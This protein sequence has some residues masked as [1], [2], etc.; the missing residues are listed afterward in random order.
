MPA[1]R[2]PAVPAPRP[3]AA[4][5]PAPDPVPAPRKPGRPRSERA[6]RAILEATLE[7][8]ARCGADGLGIEQVAARAGVGKATI[9]RRWPCKEDLLLEAV[10]R[11]CT[12]LPQPQ[13]RSVRADLNAVIEALCKEAADPR[14]ARQF[15][16]P[17]GDGLKYPRLLAR[18]SQLVME[19]RR[20]LIRSVL[21]R[22]VATGEL[23]EDTDIE[24][25]TLLLT[26]AV[27]AR[28]R[29]QKEV[30]PARYARRVVAEL[31]RG[32]AAR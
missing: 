9:Y 12:P 30:T 22:G 5:A 27:L 2:L 23:R 14:R 6:D 1:A 15:A 3:A 4:A 21:R 13:G 7:E 32:M 10:G 29:G 24:V 31:L 19:P 25:A 17:H 20:E 11:L 26:G 18:Y 8:F 16:L 28:G